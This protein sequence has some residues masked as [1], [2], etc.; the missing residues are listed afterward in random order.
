MRDEGVIA[1]PQSAPRRAG[2]LVRPFILL[3]ALLVLS[4]C[5]SLANRIGFTV[6]TKFHAA[7]FAALDSTT[8]NR[9]RRG[10][11]RKGDT[12][13]MVLIALGSPDWKVKSPT[14]EEW[15]YL[16]YSA[17]NQDAEGI[18]RG[19]F[20]VQRRIVFGLDAGNRFVVVAR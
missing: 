17:G 5:E 4:G 7:A 1:L 11:V 15:T 6:R 13:E 3:L 19:D 20:H 16:S 9:L 18:Y 12:Q 14:D 2:R 8:Q 10:V